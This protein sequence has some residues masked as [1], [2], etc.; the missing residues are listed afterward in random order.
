MFA[1][2]EI[3]LQVEPDRSVTAQAIAEAIEREK[4]EQLLS[5]LDSS[6]LTLRLI[7]EREFLPQTL[8]R[9]IK[10][11]PQD[12]N[13]L[14]AEVEEVE[15][16]EL[17]KGP[18]NRYSFSEE[19]FLAEQFYKS[20]PLDYEQL[21]YGAQSGSPLAFGLEEEYWVTSPPPDSEADFLTPEEAKTALLF[22]AWR[23]VGRRL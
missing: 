16:E 13:A 17:E 8:E 20:S 4:E 10:S 6:S 19:Q 5:Q 9:K 3:T 14:E 7:S 12:K 2:L 21:F 23:L 22:F 11:L 18:F 15:N 1:I